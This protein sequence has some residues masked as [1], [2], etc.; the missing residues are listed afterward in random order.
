MFGNFW[1][2]S[3][4]KIIENQQEKNRTWEIWVKF[5]VI[6][7]LCD[8]VGEIPSSNKIQWLA[9]YTNGWN[10]SDEVSLGLRKDC[11]TCMFCGSS[12]GML[13]SSR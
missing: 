4:G 6:T 7:R 9:V 5:A 13:R 10:R 11:E 3:R 12:V 2:I 1:D 8:F